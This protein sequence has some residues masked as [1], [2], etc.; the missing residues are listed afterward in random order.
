MTDKTTHPACAL[1]PN[2]LPGTIRGEDERVLAGVLEATDSLR[3]TLALRHSTLE[4]AG[5][6]A[7]LRV[8]TYCYASGVYASTEIEA[9]LNVDPILLYLAEGQRHG[10]QEFRQFRRRNL[11]AVQRCLARTLEMSWGESNPQSTP[12]RRPPGGYARSAFERL[13]SPRPKPN[14]DSEAAERVR[15][16]ICDDT[17]LLDE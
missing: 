4:P 7:L 17:A 5:S 13:C 10:S 8:L 3:G 11:Q 9:A 14:F 16:A 2:Q 15:K 12:G 6:Q 1:P